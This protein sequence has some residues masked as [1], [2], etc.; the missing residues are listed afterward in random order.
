MVGHECRLL[1]A[2]IAVLRLLLEEF[3]LL[4][5][6]VYEFVLL[7]NLVLKLLDKLIVGLC[8]QAVTGHD[9]TRAIL[10]FQIAALKNKLKL[11]YRNLGHLLERSAA[12]TNFREQCG[13]V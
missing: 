8:G 6:L 11:A 13:F 7:D 9:T 12:F 10:I 3:S 1:S 2:L 5:E 4:L